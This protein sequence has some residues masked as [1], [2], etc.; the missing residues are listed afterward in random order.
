MAAVMPKE[1]P[2]AIR[3][4]SWDTWSCQRC[5]RLI[6]EFG[7]TEAPSGLFSINCSNF[8]SMLRSRRSSIFG[9]VDAI[10]SVQTQ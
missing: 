2:I 3:T 9:T 5:V 1:V 10:A 8:C 7:Y 6:G 4:E